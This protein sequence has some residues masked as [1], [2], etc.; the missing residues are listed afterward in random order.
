VSIRGSIRPPYPNWLVV[1]TNSLTCFSNC[2][3]G[4]MTE[5]PQV[6]H[7]MRMSM[8]VRTAFADRRPG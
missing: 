7:L 1:L 6:R 5:W 8:P 4:S 2:E 3:R